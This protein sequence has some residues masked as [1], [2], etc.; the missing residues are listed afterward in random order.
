MSAALAAGLLPPLRLRKREE[1]RIL[2]GHPWIFSNEVDVDETPLSAFQ[3]GDAVEVQDYR[4]RP[5]GSGYVNPHSLICGRLLSRRPGMRLDADL[6][7]QRFEQALQLRSRLYPDPC[8]RLVYGEGDGLPGLVIDRYDDVLVAQF[9][10]AGMEKAR[11]SVIEAL[12][13]VLAP[14]VIHLRNDTSIRELEHLP[15]YVETV[16]GTAPDEVFVTEHGARF[17]APL[18]KGQKTGWFYDQRDNRVW[19]NRAAQGASVLDMFSYVGGFGVQAAR[20]GASHVLCVD[21]SQTALT[22][23]RK[24]AVLNGV[25]DRLSVQQGDGFDVLKQLDA[26]GERYD[27]V[28][29][30]PPAFIKRRKDMAQ[31]VKAYRRINELAMRVLKPGGYLLSCSCSF[32]M[33]REELLAQMAAA[34][35]RQ[36][37]D[38]QM[39]GYGQQGFD[40]P[41]HPAIPE[42]SYLKTVAARVLSRDGEPLGGPV[43]QDPDD[44]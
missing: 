36:G 23:A 39:L 24:N 10:T 35:H 15:A 30:D 1:R 28:I 42:T 40:H 14:R 31:G 6:L 27:Y 2:E 7:R 44:A 34:A 21:E 33:P 19:L 16:R 5:L 8:Y 25:G 3:P 4:G 41:P 20:A 17:S 18:G 26:Q 43:D 11:E 12:D 29:L 32:H 22:Q 37:R 13:A 38:L 9:T